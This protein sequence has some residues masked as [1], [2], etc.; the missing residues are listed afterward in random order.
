MKPM[1]RLLV[2]LLMLATAAAPAL[3]ASAATSIQFDVPSI[4][5]LYYHGTINFDISEAAL[6]SALAGGTEVDEG[7]LTLNGL[8]GSGNLTATPFNNP[9]ALTAS[10]D[11]FWAVRSISRVAEQTQVSV[12]LSTS[13]LSNGAGGTITI[14]NPLTDLNG[15]AP[16]GS[17]VSFGATGLSTFASGD[18]AVN[19][20]MSGVNNAGLYAGGSIVIT[21]VNL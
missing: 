8:S 1:K 19:V 4:V 14:N 17:S 7:T 11:N 3:A 20:D 2:V 6:A 16:T 10:V 15:V 13:T 18:L 21:A 9:A 5:I 12:S